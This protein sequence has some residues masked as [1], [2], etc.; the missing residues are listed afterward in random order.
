MEPSIPYLPLAAIPRF[1]TCNLAPGKV[2]AGRTRNR[3]CGGDSSPVRTR[4][5]TRQR[6]DAASLERGTFEDGI[7][8]GGDPESE[9]TVEGVDHG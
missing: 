9:C 7:R 2:H 6:V 3:S 4:K 8:T 1:S 5:T